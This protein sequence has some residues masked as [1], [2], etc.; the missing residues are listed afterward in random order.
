SGARS[1]GCPHPGSATGAAGER[2][3]AGSGG[4]GFP[5]S[6]YVAGLIA[7]AADSSFLVVQFLTGASVEA[8]H[9]GPEIARGPVRKSQGIETQVE[10]SAPFP[11]SGPADFGNGAHHIAPRGD[12]NAA[13][14]QN[15]KHA[16]EIYPVTRDSVLRAD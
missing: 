3:D 1:N 9:V 13:V 12:D 4:G 5:D 15:R 2:S 10:F 7:F 14:D 6:A 11:L 16:L 8:G